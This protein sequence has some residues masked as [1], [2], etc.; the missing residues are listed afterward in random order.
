MA[1]NTFTDLATIPGINADQGVNNAAIINAIIAATPAGE[2][3][4]LFANSLIND[5]MITLD[6]TTLVVDGALTGTGVI[7]ISANSVLVLDGSVAA[8]QTI[9]FTSSTG[10]VVFNDVGQF[11]GTI[12]GVTGQDGIDLPALAFS[13]AG[14][15][16]VV[17]S[18]TLQVVEDGQTLDMRLD[19]SLSGTN[20]DLYNDGDGGTLIL[21]PP[22]VPCFLAGTMIKTPEGETRVEDL[23]IGDLVVDIEGTPHP[24][25]WIGTRRYR[26]PLP[27]RVDVVPILISA[28]A[29]GRNV[30]DRD[31]YLSPLHALYMDGVLVPAGALVNEIS[32]R[33]CPE[34]A[35]ID[36]FHIETEAHQVILA[37]NTPAETFI[38][39]NSRT[40]FE[41]HA[42]YVKLHGRS[43]RQ[44]VMRAPRLES[45]PGLERIRRNIA[46]RAGIAAVRPGERQVI[47]FL[48]TV[49]Q[50]KITGWAAAQDQPH[51]PVTV[52]ILRGN[53]VLART[54][55]NIPRPDVKA[56]GIGNGRCGF[57]VTLP[58]FLAGIPRHEIGLR[59]G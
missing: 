14:T 31:L 2:T 9:D 8:G 34:I 29:F 21:D 30:P 7:K 38:D 47:G 45:G 43:T 25:K 16:G 18:D 12:D 55:A 4:N 48:E 57:E 52:D 19:L 22:S 3:T 39:M 49:A 17:N 13:P 40:M 50:G 20:F 1:D 44:R 10:D 5:G 37:N 11:N 6:P 42:E 58:A 56:A 23:R 46:A 35:R 36:Y 24:V 33:R 15:V 41:N 32:V 26:A 27:D 59:C 54:I 28:G 53:A 51:I